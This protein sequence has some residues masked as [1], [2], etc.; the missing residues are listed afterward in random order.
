MGQAHICGGF[1]PVNGSGS[2]IYPFLITGSPTAIHSKRP[3][4]I[5]KMNDNKNM[6]S[7]I[8][9]S[10]NAPTYVGRI[11]WFKIITLRTKIHNCVGVLHYS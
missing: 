8:A 3:H 11:C 5:N 7:T 4:T 2:H 10:I 9:E 6:D 1:K